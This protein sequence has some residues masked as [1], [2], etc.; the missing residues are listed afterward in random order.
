MMAASPPLASTFLLI[1]AAVSFLIH[2][3]TSQTCKLQT[4]PHTNNT[5][6]A[7]CA[8]LPTLKA[9]LHWTYDA[10]SKPDPTL[11]IAYVAPPARPD[12]W[13]AWALNPTGSGMVGA[14]ALVAF[15]G[16]NGSAVVKTYNISSYGPL[17]ESEIAYAVVSKMAEHTGGVIT[18]FATLALPAGSAPAVNQVWQV[19]ASVTDGVP[20]KH[21]FQPENLKSKGSLLLKAGTSPVPAPM[22]ESGGRATPSIPRVNSFSGRNGGSVLGLHGALVLL[23]VTLGF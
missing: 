5:K 17:V 3:A 18:I 13:V 4:F 9:Y 20:A 7:N 8:D 1:V 16:T 15:R 11:S 22:P 19:G 23:G 2:P 12:G 21:S 14:Q 10:S 6:F